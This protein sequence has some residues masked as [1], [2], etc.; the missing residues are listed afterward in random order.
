MVIGK[1]FTKYYLKYW[2]FFLLGIAALIVVDY[3]QL[4]IP[5]YVGIIVDGMNLE[6][7]EL[8]N[9]TALTSEALKEIILKMCIVAAIVFSGRFLWRVCIF[10]NGI[11]IETDIRNEM[12][13]HMELLSPT[14]YQQNKTGA[15]MSLY[16]NDLN[17]IS[18]SFA[19]GTLMLVDALSLGILAMIKMIRINKV[20]LLVCVVPLML[21]CV[22][23]MIM[24][25]RISR[26]TLKNLEAFSGMCDYVQEDFSGISVIKAYIK[27]KRRE[28]LFL[29][30]DQAN[31]DTCLATVSD[32]ALLGALI[33]TIVTIC[34]LSIVFIGGYFIYQASTGNVLFKLTVGQLVT[35]NALFG[36][37]IWPVQ[38]IGEL[39][40]LRGQSKASEK[41][42]SELLDTEVEINDDNVAIEYQNLTVNDIK[43]DIKFKGLDFTYPCSDVQILHDINFHIASGEMVGIMGATGSG[44]SS[45]VEV[46]LRLYNLSEGK[47][48]I[49][50][51]DIMK[52]PIKLVRDVIA[53][54]PQET[55]LFKQTID[56]N[57]AFAFEKIDKEKNHAYAFSSG[58]ESDI[59]E[60]NNGFD[61]VLGERGVTVSGG[62]KQRIS[63]A[64]ALI[65][66]AP[67]LIMDDSLS[68]VDTI[69]ES[70]ILS[71][72]RRLRKDK[73]TIIIAHRITTL[74]T[75]D[76]IIVIDD[77]RISDIGRHEE[78]L[79]RNE[80]YKREVHLQELEKELEVN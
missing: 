13:K 64:R 42:V 37:L 9:N 29:D 27:E 43:G 5:E 66:D 73:T 74:E 6:M 56:E 26:K 1:H 11:R 28:F 69:T 54:V 17:T 72:I 59:D 57:I 2:Y 36:S 4:L 67:I 15:L 32:Q 35:F 38:A 25:K 19:G 55:F 70:F 14:F 44:K 7:I 31:M 3:F 30:H 23:S 45:I 16:T 76:K 33:G 12:F 60:F 52:L 34:S 39:I 47:V 24:R 53:Y 48:F 68:A 50:D 61:T 49:D 40:N 65:K 80:I 77:G 75:L 71:E 62:Q 22:I 10:G 8:G 18:R 79:E 20:L 46:M 63:I 41:R 51:K 78:L 58:L 21:V